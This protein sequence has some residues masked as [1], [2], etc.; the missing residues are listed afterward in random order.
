MKIGIDA[1]FISGQFDGGKDQYLFNLL[2]GFE[3]NKIGKE[4]IIFCKKGKKEIFEKII[5]SAEIQEVIIKSKIN[6]ILKKFSL[7]NNPNIDEIIF[8][9]FFYK[10]IR[11]KSKID[12]LFFPKAMTGFF[13][14]D[15]TTIV[16][17]HDIQIL[18]HKERFSIKTKLFFNLFYKI[19][20]KL[21]DY[22]ISISEF[23]KNE[24]LEN[25]PSLKEKII[26]IYNPINI[27][28][29]IAKIKVNN[30]YI[31]GINI[32]YEHKNIITLLKAFNLIKNEIKH[33]L[34]LIGKINSYGESLKRYVKENDLQN[35][36][37][38]TGYIEEDKLYSILKNS[39]LYINP[40][41]FEGFGMTAVEAMIL[42]VP[43]LVAHTTAMPE[44]TK[45]LCFYYRNAYDENELAQRIIECLSKKLSYEELNY[46][47]NNI[48]SE[49]D[50]LKI[51]KEY[52]KNFMNIRGKN[53]CI[54]N[55]NKL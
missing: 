9:S 23:D 22:I 17:P 50:Y 24:I 29:N 55:N 18:S 26:K 39:S 10:N 31:L 32:A 46:I 20:F 2:R 8:R 44:V 37:I 21:R 5:P 3:E 28:K 47:S 41:I 43:T 36:V 13:K 48:S 38:F 16:I 33:N 42:G 27:K 15:A 45:N 54:N 19:D 52:Y 11:E 49:Y 12:L 1:T 40:S 53:G 14:S 4:F 35:R 30:P 6:F 7:M 51:S 34:I 25:F